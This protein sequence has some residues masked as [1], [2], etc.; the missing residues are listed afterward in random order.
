[1]ICVAIDKKHLK[2]KPFRNERRDTNTTKM[3]SLCNANYAIKV[4]DC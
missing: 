1:M 2:I 4:N 3:C